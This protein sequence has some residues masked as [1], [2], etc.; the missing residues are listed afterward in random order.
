MRM[1]EVKVSSERTSG[2]LFLKFEFIGSLKEDI[3]LEAISRWEV[4]MD[5]QLEEGE[6][7]EIIWN[8]ERMTGYESEARKG[9]QSMLKESKEKTGDI[10]IVTAKT[11]FRVAAKTMALLTNYKLKAV[12]SE[13]EIF[14]KVS[15]GS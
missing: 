3:A 15:I 14:E 12:S 7:A 1:N 8:C 11:M 10:W 6:K 13:R 2:K 5:T 4:L 9:W